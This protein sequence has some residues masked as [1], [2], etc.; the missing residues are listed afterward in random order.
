MAHNATHA[1]ENQSR[2]RAIAREHV[3]GT[4][5]VGGFAVRHS[6]ADGDLVHDLGGLLEIFAQLNTFHL[7]VDVTDFTTVFDRGQWL[8]VE[9]VLVGHATWQID[10]DQG[11]GFAFF[12]RPATNGIDSAGF[13]TEQAIERETHGAH[14]TDVNEITTAWTRHEVCRVVIPCTTDRAAHRFNPRNGSVIHYQT[15]WG[16][17]I[18]HYSRC[19]RGRLSSPDYGIVSL[20]YNIKRIDCPYLVK[21]LGNFPRGS[22]LVRRGCNDLPVPFDRFC[23]HLPGSKQT[24]HRLTALCP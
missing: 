10:V 1:W 9:A 17:L 22:I 18:L 19:G 5:F 3:V 11:F 15:L 13:V 24:F 2:A 20:T 23:S 16:G 8:G 6:A 12:A 7:G 4:A 21:Q 14:G